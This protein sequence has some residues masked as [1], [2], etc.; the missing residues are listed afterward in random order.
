MIKT[1]E[2]I[3]CSLFFRIGGQE[4]L[5]VSTIRGLIERNINFKVVTLY[6]DKNILSQIEPYK[7]YFITPPKLIENLMKIKILRYMIG[8]QILAYILFKTTVNNKKFLSFGNIPTYILCFYSIFVKNLEIY[9]FECD[10]K[11]PTKL[12]E[13]YLDFY[14][15]L[16]QFLFSVIQDPL[17]NFL[18]S[19]VRALIV[20]DDKNL[21]NALHHYKNLIKKIEL[22][23]PPQEFSQI[24]VNEVNVGD[25]I[26]SI[27]NKN[28]KFLAVVGTLDSKKNTIESIYLLNFLVK[29]G[30]NY[31][32]VIVGTGEL[33]TFL[34]NKV[35]ELNLDPF[36][37]FLGK[38]NYEEINY[39]Y[40]K[41]DCNLFFA[42]NQTWGLTPFEALR[43][44]KPSIVSSSSGCSEFLAKK[45]IGHVH[46]L[47]DTYDLCASYLENVRKTDLNTIKEKLKELNLDY[48]T[49]KILDVI[50]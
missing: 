22:V 28:K 18:L 20:I 15:K 31:S 48:Y 38:V 44:G 29:K 6:I 14:Q 50:R 45:S 35:R 11:Y 27:L 8:N 5:A 41:I 24:Q 39:I 32:L 34:R 1:N 30:L 49:N 21:R 42:I 12:R 2:F 43:F 4:N 10:I 13:S 36:V 3:I 7:E 37:Y 16:T 46:N 26:K 23:Y 9:Y 19:K 17:D 47:E 40:S 25:N 33:E